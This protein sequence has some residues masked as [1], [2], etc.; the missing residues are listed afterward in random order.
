[1]IANKTKYPLEKNQFFHT[2]QKNCPLHYPAYQGP[3]GVYPGGA[4]RESRGW[5]AACVLLCVAIVAAGVCGGL[6]FRFG[7]TGP[8]GS[9]KNPAGI[10]Q[11]FIIESREQVGSSDQMAECRSRI[12]MTQAVRG[13]AAAKL[14]AGLPDVQK[15]R[16]NE[17]QEYYV[18][19]FKIE[20]LESDAANGIRYSSIFFDA[21]NQRDEKYAEWLDDIDGN[22]P[23][24]DTGE[25]SE[26]IIVFVVEKDDDPIILYKAAEGR[27]YYFHPGV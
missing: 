3:G 2:E 9:E 8:L 7:Q 20:L 24:A 12:T 17:H 27:Y 5:I 4:N 18:A 25:V 22:F 23:V 16:L 10:G 19:K 11:A 26:G 21:M 1:M 6:I 13:E 15:P 14:I